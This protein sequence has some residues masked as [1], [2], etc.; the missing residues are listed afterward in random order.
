MNVLK[1]ELGQWR[2]NLKGDALAGIVSAFSVIPEVIGFT[3]V[4][5]VPPIYGL[6]TSVAFL[7][8]LSFLGGRPAMVSA[9]AGSMAVVV[10]TLIA[11]HGTAYLFWAVLL[12]G[13]FQIVLGLCRVGNLMRY[14]PVPVM[15]GFVDAL[16]IIIFKS[17]ITSM[18][19]NIVVTPGGIAKMLIYIGLGLLIIY[20]FPKVTDK[21]PSTLVALIVVS[22][23]SLVIALICGGNSDVKM[24]SD[25]GN[26]KGSWPGLHLPGA[27]LNGETLGIILP[28]SISLAFV[29]L[30]ETMLTN[31]VI[32][33][34]TESESNKNRE[35]VGQ[36][37]ANIFCGMLGAMPGCAMIGQAITNVKSGGRGRLSTFV[38]G[39]ILTFLL[40][41]GSVILGIIPLA[42]LIGVMIF[43]SIT[44]FNWKNLRG[45]FQNRS[46]K[47]V[48]ETIVTVVTVVVTV[49]T[50]NLAYGVGIGI[51]LFVIFHFLHRYIQLKRMR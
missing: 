41:F 5:G 29:G 49:A 9:G 19:D 38:A 11:E 3:I 36:G 43:V 8:L 20:L 10:V 6:Y 4:A 34:M 17:Q 32:D 33:E 21:V 35:C 27:P 31:Q 30:L 47:G 23:V 39:A 37:V 28:Y 15:A 50:N 24:I 42:A 44:T 46:L 1:R 13:I 14:V 25:L 22:A 7:I 45:M 2:F 48:F 12:A 51:G 26:L 40:A 16:A 18:L